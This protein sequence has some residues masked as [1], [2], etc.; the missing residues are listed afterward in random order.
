MVGAQVGPACA[1]E[2][3]K[4]AGGGVRSGGRDQAGMA[5]DGA[6]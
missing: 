1:S 3:W 2:G 5:E 6:Q 4:G